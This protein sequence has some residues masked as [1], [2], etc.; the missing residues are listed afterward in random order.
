[1]NKRVYN[2]LRKLASDQL[3]SEGRPFGRH[4]HLDYQG[5]GIE[6]LMGNNNNNNNNVPQPRGSYK[7]ADPE[8]YR[9]VR[10]EE[11]RRGNPQPTQEEPDTDTILKYFKRLG[12]K[13]TSK[14]GTVK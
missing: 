3:S 11:R 2:A 1:M 13:W 12:G 8:T 4:N 10:Q 7:E 9:R 6:R 5:P 14:P